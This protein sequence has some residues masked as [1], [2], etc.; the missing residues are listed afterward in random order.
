MKTNNIFLILAFVILVVGFSSCKKDNTTRPSVSNPTNI[1]TPPVFNSS[2]IYGVMTDQDGNTYKT[3]KIGTQTWMAENLRT[4]KYRD[5]SSIPE[6]SDS[7][8]WQNLTN[9]AQC[10]YNNTQDRVIISSFGRLYNCYAATDSRNIAPIGWHL[11]SDAEWA[12]LTDFLGG[13]YLAGDK[14]KE[15]GNT[16]WSNSNT[17]VTNESGFTALPAGYRNKDSS[18]KGIRSVVNFWSSSQPNT[19]YT[20]GRSIDSNNTGCYGTLNDQRNGFSIRCV[21]NF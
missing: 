20:F 12:I 8:A 18:F 17:G 14:I 1:S 10:T 13:Q 16:H 21:K 5:G 6:V 19:F 3:I 7:I 2:L 11:P 9:G 15:L 4:T